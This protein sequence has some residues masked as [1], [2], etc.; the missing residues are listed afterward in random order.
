MN[1]TEEMDTNLEKI[2]RIHLTADIVCLLAEQKHLTPA[3]AIKLYYE[4]DLARLMD[5]NE[6]GVLYY[7]ATDLVDMM[8]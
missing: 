8:F 5:T 4:S 7:T 6:G 2:L 3:E 1:M